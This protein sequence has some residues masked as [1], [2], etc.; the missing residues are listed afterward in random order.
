MKMEEFEH[1]DLTKA[2]VLSSDY[3]HVNQRRES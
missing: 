3:H 2:E 1:E